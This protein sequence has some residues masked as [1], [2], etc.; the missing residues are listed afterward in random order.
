LEWGRYEHLMARVA[1]AR[2]NYDEA[3]RH[4]ERS[5][6]ILKASGSPIETGRALYWAALLTLKLGEAAH[7]RQ[8]L[9][10]IRQTFAQ[11]GAAADLKRVEKELELLEI[12]N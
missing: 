7:A 12:R 11:L 9:L 2:G 4:T 6:S 8:E 3:G 5:V 10:A 1:L